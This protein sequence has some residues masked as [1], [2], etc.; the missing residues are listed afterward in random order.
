MKYL[1]PL[2]LVPSIAY[3]DPQAKC[4][5]S[6]KVHDFRSEERRVGKEC[7]D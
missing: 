5:T 1:I 4:E 6:Q 7:Y 3:A 2:L